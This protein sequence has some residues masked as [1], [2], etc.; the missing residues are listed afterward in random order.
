MAW[1][2]HDLLGIIRWTF[3]IHTSRFDFCSSCYSSH[4]PICP[5][6]SPSFAPPLL[7]LHLTP[8]TFPHP[9]YAYGM[10]VALFGLG[11]GPILLTEV[12]CFGNETALLQCHAH[13]AGSNSMCRH[14]DDV[15]VIC[16][17]MWEER[18]EREG[19]RE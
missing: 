10:R 13:G 19:G 4:L 3:H 12:D 6:T 8:P 18:R 2:D 9:G 5:S 15:S 16:P 7:P 1:A 11:T 14:S 17:C